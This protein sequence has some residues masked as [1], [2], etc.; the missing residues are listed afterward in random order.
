M[1][2]S[3]HRQATQKNNA[4]PTGS[5]FNY[6][7]VLQPCQRQPTLPTA[8]CKH[9]IFCCPFYFTAG[10]AAALQLRYSFIFF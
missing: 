1:L 5:P 7:F 4:L 2:N 6:F 10:N 8:V 9:E 3:Q